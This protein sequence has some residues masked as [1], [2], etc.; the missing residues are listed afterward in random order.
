MLVPMN[1][2][3]FDASDDASLVWACIEPTIQKIRGKNVTIKLDAYQYLSMGQR[4]LLMF[5]IMY[6]HSS[7]GVLEFYRLIPYLPAKRGIWQELK[8]GMQYFGD[9]DMLQ[10]LSEME[11]EYSILEEKSHEAGV[12]RFDDYISHL[13]KDSELVSSIMRHSIML[14]ETFSKTIK[15]IGAYIRNNPN[16]FVQFQE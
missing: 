14:H 11:E 2:H 16:E 12:E 13:D 10:L 5:Q 7:T 1:R 4:A 15:V 3:A 8:R 9:S 6:G